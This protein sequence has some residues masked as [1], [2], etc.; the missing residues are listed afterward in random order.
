MAK[1]L[2]NSLAISQNYVNPE[3]HASMSV[4][5]DL[6]HV[7]IDT[8]SIEE[9]NSYTEE[10]QTLSTNECE[11]IDSQDELDSWEPEHTL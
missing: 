6:R 3:N 8:E 2:H 9:G 11:I 5:L 7:L 1:E 4:D 10:V